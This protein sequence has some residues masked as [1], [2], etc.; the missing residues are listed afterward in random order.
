MISK[1]VVVL[2]LSDESKEL[3][4]GIW[5]FWIR[6]LCMFRVLDDEIL[7]IR[8]SK[9]WLLIEIDSIGLSLSGFLEIMN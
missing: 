1:S 9:V 3:Q 2:M 4:N 5:T 8:G 6:E 7:M